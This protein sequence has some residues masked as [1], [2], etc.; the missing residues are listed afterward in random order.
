MFWQVLCRLWL[1][2]RALALVG[3][4]MGLS[5]HIS[6]LSLLQFS[7][8]LSWPSFR[9]WFW[10]NFCKILISRIYFRFW[11]V[12]I[13]LYIFFFSIPFRHLVG[14]KRKRNRAPEF[15]NLDHRNFFFINFF[16]KQRSPLSEF[17][18]NV[19]CSVL[20]FKS[21][22]GCSTVGRVSFKKVPRE[23]AT[24]LTWVWIPAGAWSGW[25]K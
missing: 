17:Y 12:L 23:G 2:F 14:Q 13:Y 15:R 8:K 21:L 3:K 7:Q 10:R 16:S 19:K 25:K 4:K 5:F 20:I 1:T 22:G 6:S 9:I 18:W 24:L 11:I